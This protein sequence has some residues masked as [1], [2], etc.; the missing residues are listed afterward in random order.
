VP[1]NG[2]L[3]ASRPPGT[4]DPFDPETAW[5]TWLPAVSIEL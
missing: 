5:G 1:E 2:A 3:G 4:R